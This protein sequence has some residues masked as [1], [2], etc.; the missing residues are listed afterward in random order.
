M[1][2]AGCAWP[3]TRTRLAHKTTPPKRQAQRFPGSAHPE[4]GHNIVVAPISLLLL[5]ACLPDPGSNPAPD[6]DD[7][8]VS[9]CA[10]EAAHTLSATQIATAPRVSWTTEPASRTWIRFSNGDGRVRN[11]PSQEP[12]AEH[13]TVLV[14]IVPGA[15]FGYQVIVD[16][17]AG[18]R[19]VAE[20]AGTNGDLPG[21]L[22]QMTESMAGDGGMPGLTAVPVI[23]SY[24]QS[25]NWIELLDEAGR[26][27]WAYPASD[28]VNGAEVQ[29]TSAAVAADGLGILF[30]HQE[31]SAAA[32][33]WIGEVNFDGTFRVVA[34]VVGLHTDFVQLEEGRIAALNWEVREIGDARYLGDRVVIIEADGQVR[35][36]WSSFDQLPFDASAEWAT[37]FYADD[38]SVADWSHVNSVSWD[39]A[40]DD[41]LITMSAY[42]GT[43]RIDAESGET[44]WYY[45]SYDDDFEGGPQLT[46]APHS[47]K[48]LPNG[49]VLVFNRGDMWID[50]M[51]TCSWA[52]ELAIDAPGQAA[53]EVA[54]WE[55]ENC[56]LVTFLGTAHRLDE[57]TTLV[58]WTSAGRIDQLSADGETLWSVGLAAGHAFGT[59]DFMR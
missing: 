57:E 40:S 16:D 6:A 53:T 56:T 20:G 45:G 54:R 36:L 27:V 50:P 35:P 49:N 55:G 44:L 51:G 18:E 13:E 24:E 11:S 39:A 38:P 30:N 29:V 8:A 33:G 5:A 2:A 48:V 32:P 58:D 3:P 42:G 1:G 17:G 9:T 28:A 14:G 22:P 19:C 59:A 47:A 41:L 10:N 43:A 21:G 7:T 34:E 37:G 4:N 26:V 25:D 31:R 12:G 15:E 46:A 23:G 52:S